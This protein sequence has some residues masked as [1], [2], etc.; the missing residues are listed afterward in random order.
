M[1]T[2]N[3]EITDGS[4]YT[5][6]Y[7]GLDSCLTDYGLRGL[8]DDEL[9]TNCVV[10]MDGKRITALPAMDWRRL[11]DNLISNSATILKRTGV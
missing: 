4:S 11:R 9:V 10:T 2:V 8:F 5:I 6:E 3:L 1:F 7:P